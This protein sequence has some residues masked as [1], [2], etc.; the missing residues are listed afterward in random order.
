[1]KEGPAVDAYMAGKSPAIAHYADQLD[2]TAEKDE[3]EGMNEL[4]RIRALAGM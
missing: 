2:K 3:D 4:V 1:M